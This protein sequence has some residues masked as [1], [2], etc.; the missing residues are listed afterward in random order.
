[1]LQKSP[2]G[3]ANEEDSEEV[4]R[5]EK[6]RS[7]P[8]FRKY[9]LECVLAVFTL[10]TQLWLIPLNTLMNRKSCLYT[11]EFNETLCDDLENVEDTL[12]NPVLAN[13]NIF[14]TIRETVINVPGKQRTIVF[15]YCG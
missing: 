8:F 2:V 1:M 5:V 4:A 13:T 11:F 14:S 3:S 6:Y 7:I 9:F 10:T 12:K 15:E